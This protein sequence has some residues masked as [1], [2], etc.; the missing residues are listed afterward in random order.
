L[1]RGTHFGIDCSGFTQM[2]L[3][4]NNIQVSRDASQQV[5]Q[6]SEVAKW[7]EARLGDLAFFDNEAGKVTHVGI[8]LNNELIIHA[9]GKVKIDKFSDA[10]IYS[11]ALHR[12]THRLHSIRRFE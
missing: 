1:G 2:V 3:K 8:L 4:L 12:I 6:G 11:S 10:G 9:S 7:N 5:L